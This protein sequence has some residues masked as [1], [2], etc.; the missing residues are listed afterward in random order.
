[1]SA[2]CCDGTDEYEGRVKCTNTCWEAGKASREKLVK[3]LAI[4]KEGLSIR[5]SEIENA[6]LSRQQHEAKLT[7]LQKEEKTQS[8]L[9]RKLT[10]ELLALST[11]ISSL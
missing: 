2:D 3:K 11:L 9:V 7:S 4:H 10:G 6:K 5:R 1:M 8:E